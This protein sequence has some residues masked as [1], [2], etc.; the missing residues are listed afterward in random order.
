MLAITLVSTSVFTVEVLL[1]IIVEGFEPWVF[2][3]SPSDGP[4]NTMDFVIVLA[5][6]VFMIFDFP[7]LSNI[8]KLIRLIRL[9]TF[10]KGV[11]QLRVIAAGLANVSVLLA[12]SS[13]CNFFPTSTKSSNLFSVAIQGMASV[14]YIVILLMLIIYLFGIMGC[15]FFG[16]ND[17]ARFG[18]VAQAMLS[19]FQ[20][21]TLASWTGIA[22]TSWYGCGEYQGMSVAHFFFSFFPPKGL[23]PKRMHRKPNPHP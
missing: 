5:G 20:V 18:T 14:S 7:G 8:V 11:S 12:V 13:S 4:I 6:Y 16:Q 17:P 1:K 22:Y 3:T 2:F 21:S 23:H 9:L 15:I 10:V 19:L